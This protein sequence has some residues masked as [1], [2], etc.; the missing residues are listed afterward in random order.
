MVQFA[1]F[2]WKVI[3]NKSA[4]R[5]KVNFY[6]VILNEY[7]SETIYSYGQTQFRKN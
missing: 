5:Y 3:N 7:Q 6:S 4:V 2:L 1:Y